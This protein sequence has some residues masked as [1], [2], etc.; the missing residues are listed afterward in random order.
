[1]THMSA[2]RWAAARALRI[3]SAPA[4]FERVRSGGAAM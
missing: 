2:Y 4:G 1:M 3:S